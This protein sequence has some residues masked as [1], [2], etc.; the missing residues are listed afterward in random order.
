MNKRAQSQLGMI[1]VMLVVVALTASCSTAG[2]EKAREWIRYAPSIQW[3]DELDRS[4]WRVVLDSKESVAEAV[5]QT[6]SA[7]PL[8]DKEA[9]EFAHESNVRP[10]STTKPF[11]I[12]A[13]RPHTGTTA[14]F[15]Y[16]DKDNN[17]TLI[18]SALSH[19]PLSPERRPIVIWLEA[20][21]REIYLWSSVAA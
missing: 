16:R 1:S 11:L 15:V 2:A 18:G 14:F 20:A 7:V 5:L 17:L 3:G 21:P 9:L 12:R 10:R 19:Y 6:A 13:V 8:T 4:Q